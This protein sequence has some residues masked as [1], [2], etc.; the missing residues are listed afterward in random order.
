M[1]YHVLDS[2]CCFCLLDRRIE[3]LYT[4]YSSAEAALLMHTCRHL[5]PFNHSLPF[6]IGSKQY[7]HTRSVESFAAARLRRDCG[8]RAA[9]AIAARGGDGGGGGGET[10]GVAPRNPPHP[11]SLRTA[12]PASFLFSF[13][14]RHR[15][16]PRDRPSEAYDKQTHHKNVRR[17]SSNSS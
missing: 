5:W 16:A 13:W 14:Y 4:R 3:H 10:A 6:C 12:L 1:L 7:L 11:H 17:G 15:A 9:A 8:C 2:F